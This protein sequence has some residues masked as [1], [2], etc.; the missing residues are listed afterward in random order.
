MNLKYLLIG[1]LALMLLGC[2]CAA[3]L[4]FSGET[5]QLTG[6]QTGDIVWNE[7]NFGG[8]CYSLSD[9]TCIGTET[10]TIGAGALEGPDIDRFIDVGNL[11][12][13]TSP[14]WQEYE[15]HKN[16]GLTVEG[17][18]YGGDSGY[19]SEFWMGERYVAVGGNASKLS[20]PLVEFND[21]D[22]KS[23]AIGEE[24][25][26]GD[27]FTLTAM[28]IDLEGGK[29]WL[30][31]CRNGSELD[32]E[33]IDTSSS[34]LQ[35][36]VYTH[37]EDVVGEYDVPIFS[38][39]VSEIFRGT[40]SSMIRV[41][42]VF[43]IDNDIIQISTREYYGNMQVR[44]IT[45]GEVTLGNRD[46]VYLG[47][48]P[49]T[50]QIM[51]N[52]S[53]KTVNNDSAIE[54]YP[55]LIRDELPVLSGGGGFI[56]YYCGWYRW[57]LY[58][59]YT[60][61]WNQVDLGGAKA[62][63][64]LCKDGMVV[65]ERIL[66]EEQRAPVD[67]D[68]RYSYVR[69]GTEIVNATL[70]SAFRGC[71]ANAA[72]LVNLTQYSDADGTA[73]IV[74][75]S[76]LYRTGD[77]DGMAGELMGGY[78]LTVKDIDLQGDKAWL[79]L[80]TDGI[81]LKEDILMSDDLF[82]YRNDDGLESVDCMV[83]AVFR[84]CD[85][86]IVKLKNVTQ[87]AGTGVRL[88]E[89]ESMTY[90]AGVNDHPMIGLWA[91][92]VGYSLSARDI[93]LDGDKVWLLLLK[94]GEVMKDTII[95]SGRC[96][97]DRWF[98]YSNVTGALVFSTYV[99]VVFR[100]TESNLVQLR[101][102][103]Q[104]S[105][106]DGSVFEWAKNIIPIG[107]T[108]ITPPTITGYSPDS[109]VS[110]PE[111]AIREFNIAIDQP[112]DVVWYIDGTVVKDT[113][114]GVTSAYYTN[115]SAKTGYWNVSAVASNANGADMQAWWW[116][117]NPGGYTTGNR[118]WEEGM[119]DPYRWTAQSFS[120]FYY[121]INDGL[122]TEALTITGID[123][124]LDEGS[125]VYETR[126]R[127]VNFDCSKWGEYDVI[128][129]AAEMYFAG[130]NSDTR[131]ITDE[132]ISL[133]SN[134]MLSKIL[135]DED[136]KHTIST[137]ASLE[138]KEGYEIRIIQ[139]D[140][141]GDKAQIELLRDGKS[142][143][144]GI[145]SNTPSTYT[146]TRDIGSVDDVPIV[147]IR[148]DSVFAGTESDMLV[149]KGIFQISEDYKS[150]ESGDQYGEME[151]TSTSSSGITMKNNDTV[152]LGEGELVDL[153]GDIKFLVADSSTLRFALYAEI[154]EPGTHNIR[155]TVYT[156]T[157]TPTWTPMNFEG[158]YYDIDED[159]GTGRLAIK[160]S[161][162]SIGE[163]KLVYTTTVQ[164]VTFD[165]S[166]WGKYDVI[167]FMDEKYFAGYNAQTDNDITDDPISLVSNKMLSEVLIDSDRKHT[168]AT[169][170]SLELGEGYELK[171]I[172]LDVGGDKAEIEL[173]RNGKSVD[174]SLIGNTPETYTYTRDIGAVDDVPLIAIRVDSVFAG[175]ESN[176]LVIK[177]VFQISE[178]YKSIEA[179]DRYV[180]M[181]IKSTSSTGITMKN[182]NDIDLNEGG[183][184]MIMD[185]IGFMT[186]YDGDRYCPFVR[187]SVGPIAAL[188]IE[189]PESLIVGG[190]SVITV[191]SY[192]TP[193]EG[194]HVRFAGGNL[195][196]T[197]SNGE[198][199]F[200]PDTAGMFMIT[201]I[202]ENY[203]FA[204][205]A[206]R[207]VGGST[208]TADAVIALQLAVS[209]GWDADADVSGDGKVTSLDALMILQMAVKDSG[210]VPE[211]VINELMP[212]P[213]GADR[214]NET[215][216]LYNCGDEPANIGGWV[217]K[218]EDSATY[219]I[220]A[221]TTI[222]PYGYYLATKVQLNNSGGQVLLYRDG[223]EV[224]RRIAYTHST[225]GLSWQRRID[226]LDTD[227]DGDWIERNSTF[228]VPG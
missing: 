43:L 81:V 155:G 99:D 136:D 75:G 159:L 211:I 89:N 212:N 108:I 194:A 65:D 154:T 55:H 185:A 53:F 157:E 220:P 175:I 148:V 10:L 114:K 201:A 198:V 183:N 54:F 221:G 95:D 146:Y 147:V 98:K 213:I 189:L 82:E 70:K 118:I 169:G 51:G 41:K 97:A 37:T 219:N 48:H 210:A 164:P 149:I 35:D 56:S 113:E 59:N 202:K 176:M 9:G 15:L 36:R 152:G 120:G 200:T 158:F 33:V 46:T 174:T 122:S 7:S 96:D 119:G 90:P 207:I 168:V 92:E 79:E 38:C 32:N 84:G 45:H 173:I 130:Y 76:H 25:D 21:T 34:D 94:D 224:D 191:T 64:V 74:D 121:D 42:Y 22:T 31:L 11:T 167:G 197:N 181:E 205:I 112:S 209:G 12:Y 17:D 19:W 161:G 137:G 226:G 192:G 23:L 128:G 170:A 203:D 106:I 135:I 131:E 102:T 58:E 80:S 163:D 145:I 44:S 67:S 178:D 228:G 40:D 188:K 140:L 50:C 104:Y 139:L 199:R 117:V 29:V 61:G 186:S 8:F 49:S 86:N 187:R 26:L 204:Y 83:E 103:T 47:Q 126:P 153:M 60:L 206:V 28:A 73:L 227:S 13:T 77:P 172:Q 162:T 4:P 100:G 208:T 177:G 138:L 72:K 20:K 66:T 30:S 124:S 107:I 160:E 150:V 151:I 171:I 180:E 142:V 1:L 141:K 190:E 27:G 105:E 3:A 184:T 62:W 24:W 78:V 110:D 57:D 222:E 14:I 116:A 127:S 69:N 18:R 165:Y 115:N 215:T 125:I 52:L 93:G 218:N 223:D 214:G 87:Y 5:A 193:V 91:L 195:G 109:H 217:L 71:A 6:N 166:G 144:T 101:H 129:F 156:T 143:D 88:I 225:E 182:P 2:G 39:Y 134:K 63:I 123:R 132:T 85:V 133:V 111:G 16:L 216:E 68:S 179:G 196:H